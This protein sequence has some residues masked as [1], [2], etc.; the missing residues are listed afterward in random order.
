MILIEFIAKCAKSVWYLVLRYVIWIIAARDCNHCKNQY[1]S[2]YRGEYIC[3]LSE[4][5]C[6][7]SPL[8]TLFDRDKY[9]D[10]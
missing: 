9:I 5:K 3:K 8:Y 6:K 2:L 10:V 4:S 7:K 1:Y